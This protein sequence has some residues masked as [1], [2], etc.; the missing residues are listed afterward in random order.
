MIPI[1]LD[2]RWGS[3]ELRDAFCWN[4]RSSGQTPLTFARTTCRDLVLPD[5]FAE[6]MAA[7]IQSQI[8]LKSQVCEPWMRGDASFILVATYH[9]LIVCAIRVCLPD[10]N[11]TQIPTLSAEQMARDRELGLLNIKVRIAF[12]SHFLFSIQR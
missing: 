9:I 5:A 4:T 3:I 7:E 2:L 8:D 12:L 10:F 1:K 6:H 11:S